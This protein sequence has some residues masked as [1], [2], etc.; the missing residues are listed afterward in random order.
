VVTFVR[1]GAFKPLAFL[2][3]SVDEFQRGFKQRSQVATMAK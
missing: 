3:V 1:L 2:E